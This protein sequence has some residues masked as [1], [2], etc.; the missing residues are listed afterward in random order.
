[1]TDLSPEEKE[2]LGKE[3]SLSLSLRRLV[4]YLALSTCLVLSWHCTIDIDRDQTV[5]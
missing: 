4:Y 3:I 5:L 2:A 1:M